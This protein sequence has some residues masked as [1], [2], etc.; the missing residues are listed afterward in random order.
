MN[1]NVVD[2]L[3]GQCE[4]GIWDSFAE[5]RAVRTDLTPEQLAEV[6]RRTAG[7]WAELQAKRGE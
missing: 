2:R 6:A 1:T 4:K 7:L 5:L 3:V